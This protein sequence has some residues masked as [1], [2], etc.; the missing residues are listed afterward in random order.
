MHLLVFRLKSE[1]CQHAVHQYEVLPYVWGGACASF[2]NHWSTRT[3]RS[4]LSR[5]AEFVILAGQLDT[6]GLSDVRAFSF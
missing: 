1:V 2:L 5:P 6:A 3:R 4:Q